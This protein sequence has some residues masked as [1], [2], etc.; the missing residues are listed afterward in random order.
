MEFEDLDILS[1][2][3]AC[4]LGNDEDD[5]I[6]VKGST[7]LMRPTVEIDIVEPTIIEEMKPSPPK[8]Q[9]VFTP[10]PKLQTIF[11]PPPVVQLSPPPVASPPPVV[12]LSPLIEEISD[13]D[14]QVI[15]ELKRHTAPTSPPHVVK[16]PQVRV[17]NRAS[18]IQPIVQEVDSDSDMI[19]CQLSQ[20]QTRIEE[21]QRQVNPEQKQAQTQHVQVVVQNIQPPAAPAPA[22]VVKALRY[23]VVNMTQPE[24]AVVRSE[25]MN[26]Y[27]NLRI[28]HP[29]TQ[30]PAIGE[31]EDLNQ[32]EARYAPFVKTEM[33]NASMSKYKM[34]NI[35]L[36]ELMEVLAVKY[37]GIKEA[38]GFTLQQIQQYD[39]YELVVREYAEREGNGQPS[40]WP[41]E[42]RWLGTSVLN[43]ILFLGLAFMGRWLGDTAA[44]PLAA[45]VNCLLKNSSP[46]A[47]IGG[48]LSSMVTAATKPTPVT[49]VSNVAHRPSWLS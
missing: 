47:G 6:Y 1:D 9:T 45:A 15:E 26:K 31:H 44:K 24:Q 30:Y 12:Q 2:V 20:L 18:Q 34:W 7:L 8:L 28:K 29:N 14:I 32:I 35:L 10:P 42:I 39:D 38:H 27:N 46:D 3:S 21:L 49:T 4:I 19:K 40:P 33:V 37:F 25:Y 13:E 48:I 22:P 43:F 23:D 36:W 17:F 11:T 41:V 5:D 16:S